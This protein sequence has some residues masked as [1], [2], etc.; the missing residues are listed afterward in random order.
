MQR[1]LEQEFNVPVRWSE[2]QS[3]NTHENAVK[4]AEIFSAARITRIVLVT[5][6]FDMPRARAEFAAQG[7]DSIPAPTGIPSWEFD[8]PLDALPS[9]AALQG[10]Y[11]AL[12][13]IRANVV[14]WVAL[15]IENPTLSGRRA[16]SSLAS[17]AQV[18]AQTTS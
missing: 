9:L 17:L 5:H 13:E 16:T 7:I 12:Y 11:F 4:S 1:A 3:R 10:S 15:R 14:R 18:G 2:T 8:S 6:G